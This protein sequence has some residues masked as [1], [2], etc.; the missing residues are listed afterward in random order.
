MHI[1]E[2]INYMQNKE[3][4][5]IYK[6]VSPFLNFGLQMAITIVVFVF[7]GWWLDTKFDTSPL[8]ILILTF[9]GIFGSLYSFIK[10][11]IDIDKKPDN[12]K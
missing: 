6:S 10:K 5:E 2:L 3:K 7:V 9:I 12:K 4:K 8:W 11:V 1:N